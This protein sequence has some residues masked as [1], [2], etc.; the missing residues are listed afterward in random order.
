MNNRKG[1]SSHQ[2]ANMVTDIWLSPPEIPAALGKFDLDPC[3]FD[4]H[5]WQVAPK[6]YTESDNG[7]L[8][9]WFGRI[10]MNPPYGLAINAWLEKLANHCNG[11]ALTFDRSETKAFHRFVFPYADSTFNFEGRLHFYDRYGNR[12]KANAG[13][14]SVLIAYGEENSE[15]IA[16]SGLK[17]FH[18]AVNSVPVVVVI[19]SPSWKSVVTIA[20]KRLNGTASV[21][22]VYDLVE[23]IAPDKTQKNK[24]FKEKIRQQLQIHFTRIGRGYYSFSN[25]NISQ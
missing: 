23:V 22:Q 13:A 14:P 11:I 19:S 9:P 20:V 7:L 16:R 12:A 24:N 3:S 4:E 15:A 2:S 8:M 17:G 25:P 18:R 6:Y 21:K 1:M 10:W 5:P